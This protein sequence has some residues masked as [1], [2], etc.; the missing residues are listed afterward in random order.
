MHMGLRIQLNYITK[1]VLTLTHIGIIQCPSSLGGEILFTND[2]A[3]RHPWV[4]L[5]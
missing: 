1:Q 5:R 2:V 4:F 3:V